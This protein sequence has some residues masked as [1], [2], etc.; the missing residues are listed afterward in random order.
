LIILPFR[1]LENPSL[2]KIHKPLVFIAVGIAPVLKG[3]EVLRC[4]EYPLVIGIEHSLLQQL[5]VIFKKT[6]RIGGGIFLIP[7]EDEFCP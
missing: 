3:S 7:A 1:Q 6:E 5:P 2:L 4:A